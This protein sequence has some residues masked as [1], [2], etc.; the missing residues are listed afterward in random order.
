MYYFEI[1]EYAWENRKALGQQ[2]AYF[3]AGCL[4]SEGDIY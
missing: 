4:A 1:I 2:N 3:C